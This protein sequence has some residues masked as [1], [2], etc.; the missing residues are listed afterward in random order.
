MKQLLLSAVALLGLTVSNS[1][2][3][4]GQ[5]K[6]VDLDKPLPSEVK[7]TVG[8]SIYF[9]RG[10]SEGVSKTVSS[11][12]TILTEQEKRSFPRLTDG[13]VVAGYAATNEGSGDIEVARQVVRP[14]ATPS[15]TKIKVTVEP[16][17]TVVDLDG[18][19]PSTLDVMVGQDIIFGGRSHNLEGTIEDANGGKS[20]VVKAL[21]WRTSPPVF[22]GNKPGTCTFT[23][24]Y[25][26]KQGSAK[27]THTMTVV[28]TEAVAE[29]DLGAALPANLTVRVGTSIRF[30]SNTP[31]ARMFNS[32]TVI[33][34]NG[35]PSNGVEAS[36]VRRY[37]PAFEAKNAGTYQFTL[38]FR[39]HPNDPAQTHT[40]NITVK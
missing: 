36:P 9:H 5:L 22:R 24:T 37:P 1:F 29:V 25:S 4:E 34:A 8:D 19:L 11:K 39:Y 32:A 28:V 23:V 16:K 31:G 21:P 3:A 26:E 35:K 40:I 17:R 7:L 12:S 6:L 18:K 2:A 13:S 33:G 20:D 14:G 38:S 27:K 15:V 30:T 10:D